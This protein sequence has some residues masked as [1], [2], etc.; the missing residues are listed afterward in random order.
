MLM[1]KKEK[2]EN[3]EESAP[4]QEVWVWVAAILLTVL[5]AVG[6]YSLFSG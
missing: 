3:E 6:A 1:P 4:T 2:K 5:C